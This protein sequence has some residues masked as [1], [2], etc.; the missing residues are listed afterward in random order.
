M[1]LKL[2]I[3]LEDKNIKILTTKVATYK[4]KDGRLDFPIS[5][6]CQCPTE[7]CTGTI[8]VTKHS[9]VLSTCKKCS[10]KHKRKGDPLNWELYTT[11]ISRVTVPLAKA[12]PHLFI[13]EE[14]AESL[15]KGI[16]Y[17]RKKAILKCPADGCNGTL[18]VN[19]RDTNTRT[20]LKC[21]KCVHLSLRKRPYERTYN[22]AI[23][24]VAQ[25]N[26]KINWLL[27]Y[28]EFASLCSIP[29]CHYCNINLNR[30]EY[31]SEAGV[32]SLLLDRKD[33]NKDYTLDNSVPCCPKCN[34]TK[35][36]RV[37]YDEMVLVMKHRGWWVEKKEASNV[38]EK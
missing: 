4:R 29:N 33:S 21:I 34:F 11:D 31:A 1:S 37:S 36:D 26:K 14:V 35:N 9:D 3:L 32:N 22:R 7:N 10:S 25:R 12:N 27:S 28:E 38:N 16:P 8:I 18:V 6:I 17:L 5:Y 13:R 19:T 24:G 30:A 15:K 2:R 20:E 23:Y